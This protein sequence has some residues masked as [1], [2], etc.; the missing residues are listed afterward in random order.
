MRFFTRLKRSIRKRILFRKFGEAWNAPKE[1][2]QITVNFGTS[3]PATA[4]I[5][6]APS[7]VMP[8]RS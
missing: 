5:I 4:M 1:P 3:E 8:R 7:L 2:L 6:L